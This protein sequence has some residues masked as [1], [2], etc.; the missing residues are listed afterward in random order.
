MLGGGVRVVALLVLAVL[1]PSSA[2]G[3]G[4]P[5]AN[6]DTSYTGNCGPAF[7]V[8]AWTDAGG[9]TDP[10]QYSTIR[11]ADVN[12]DGTD[13][14]L[15]RNHDGLEVF[16]FDTSIGQ[17]RPQVDA[18]DVRQLV[19]AQDANGNMVSDFASPS[20]SDESDPHR[21]TRPY[22][23]STIQAADIDG[24]PG[25]EILARFWDGMR[26]Y[27]YVPPAGGK[28]IDGGTWRRIGTGGPFSDSDGWG[29]PSLYLTIKTADVDGDKKAE[30]VSR[31]TTGA[32]I[33]GWTG[34]G[35][36]PDGSQL[37]YGLFG[38]DCWRRALLR[39]LPAVRDAR[40]LRPAAR[41]AG[42]HRAAEL[43]RGAAGEADREDGELDAV[44]AVP[45]VPAGRHGR[46]VELAA[47]LARLAGAT[48]AWPA[49]NQ[50]PAYY[51]TMLNADI[52]GAPGDEL[53]GMLM[54]GLQIRQ[55]QEATIQTTDDADTSDPSL[56]FG[57][58]DPRDERARRVERHAVVGQQS[59]GARLGGRRHRHGRPGHRSEGSRPGNDDRRVRRSIHPQDDGHGQLELP[60]RARPAG[61]VRVQGSAGECLELSAADR[62]RRDLRRRDPAWFRHA[63]DVTVEV[64][65]DVACAGGDRQHAASIPGGGG[66]CGRRTSTGRR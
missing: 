23:Y 41:G 8:P 54:G 55:L 51:E 22:Y 26:V 64:P 19:S 6:A 20:I 47:R 11:L 28:N 43:A 14:L 2:W 52:D 63:D 42:C 12:G 46:P 50:S 3:A 32:A 30:L 58:M 60:V 4:C 37:T 5:D 38:S 44:V 1:T 35:W 45:A 62:R 10:S 39:H 24:Q 17:W 49:S 7:A 59:R 56:E 13:E 15:G 61:A 9:F 25:E 53:L 57:G 34:S 27:K 48:E 33:Y 66:R 65:R 18:N 31:T 40:W 29:A 16:W 21:I 36:A